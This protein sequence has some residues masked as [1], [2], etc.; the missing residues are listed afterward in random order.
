M[1]QCE[2]IVHVSAN[3][4]PFRI[5]KVAETSLSLSA[6][7]QPFRYRPTLLDTEYVIVALYTTK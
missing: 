1:N 5:N 6:L 7:L 3:A 2:I 4:N